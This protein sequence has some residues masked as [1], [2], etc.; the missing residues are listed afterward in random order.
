MSQASFDHVGDHPHVRA[1]N[2]VQA[3]G[4]D[5]E[6]TIDPTMW[7]TTLALARRAAEQ[8]HRA[9]A[10]V[11][12]EF[13]AT[14]RP[15]ALFLR[16]F[17][18]EA[19]EYFSTDCAPD[20]DGG[21]VTTTLAGPSSVEQKIVAALSQRLPLLAIANPSQ[22]LTSRGLI[23]RLQLPNEG[24]QQVVLNLIEHAHLIVMDC[25]SFATGVLWELDSITKAG[26]QDA[27]LI[28][29][30]AR[31]VAAPESAL[32]EIAEILGSAVVKRLPPATKSDAPLRGFSRVAH[33]D[34]IDLEPL[35]ASPLLADLLARAA[36]IAAQ[37]PIFD[38]QQYARWLNNEGVGLAAQQLWS[39]AFQMHTQALLVRQHLDDREGLLV[40]QR[41]LGV[42]CT[43][44]G[45]DARA[46]PYFE[47]ALKLAQE[48][49]HP[50]E[51]GVI[52]AYKGFAY[53]QMGQRDEAIRWLRTGYQLQV[54]GGEGAVLEDT[55]R[56]LAELHREAGEGDAMVECYR[57]LRQHHRDA[58]NRAGELRA[59]LRLAE[60]YW[61]ADQPSEALTLFEEGLKISREIGDSEKEALCAE[62]IQ[63]LRDPGDE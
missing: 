26:R 50:G 20:R 40:T 48:L 24:W 19:Y 53:R 42:L 4:Q 61:L 18:V 37:A 7:N 15:F 13:Q 33:E 59:N 54:A 47:D 6:A 35:E 63:R 12:H 34:E 36:E 38:P 45:E 62:A 17:E 11:M 3:E 56:Q 44:A 60:T 21:T 30:P 8:S 14:K 2:R 9:A 39:E 32:Q 58:G 10:M 1:V 16:S 28:V 55:L 51:A 41:N 57:V 23:P 29:L 46:L 5:P 52:A 43:D 25:D 22:L 27:T 49:K 31:G